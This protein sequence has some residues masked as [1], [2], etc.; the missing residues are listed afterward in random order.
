[1]TPIQHD[2]QTEGAMSVDREC[3]P[4]YGQAP[5][6]QEIARLKAELNLG[7]Q[8]SERDCYRVLK[9]CRR[10]YV[11]EKQ[12]TRREQWVREVCKSL[13]LS[14]MYSIKD[15]SPPTEHVGGIDLEARAIEAKHALAE[16]KEGG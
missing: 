7:C 2:S 4:K 5:E 1:M 14:I 6:A 15:T 12:A 3:D 16:T 9:L 13:I 8:F 10:Y 11:R